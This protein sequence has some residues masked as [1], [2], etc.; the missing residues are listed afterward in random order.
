MAKHSFQLSALCEITTAEML[1]I[2]Q[3]SN[4]V[5]PNL[6]CGR[7]YKFSIYFELKYENSDV[8]W[9]LQRVAVS[10]DLTSGFCIHSSLP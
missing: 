1:F 4:F 3:T 10:C 7:E 8:L 2:Y 6:V 9:S 5:W